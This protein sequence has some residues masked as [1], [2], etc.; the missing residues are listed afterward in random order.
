MLFNKLSRFLI[1]ILVCFSSNLLSGTG[2]ASTAS[3]SSQSSERADLIRR[4]FLIGLHLYKQKL[5]PDWVKNA[6]TAGGTDLTSSFEEIG[7]IL[8]E[9]V[10]YKMDSSK[11]PTIDYYVNSMSKPAHWNYVFV[12]KVDL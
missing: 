9:I 3:Q 12:N 7:K 2:N 8:G 6:K 4:G 11:A 10:D 5:A 1:L